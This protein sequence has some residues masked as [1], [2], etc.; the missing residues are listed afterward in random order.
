MKCYQIL[1]E[2]ARNGHQLT[3]SNYNIP[4]GLISKPKP[5]NLLIGVLT[6]IPELLRQTDEILEEHFG[7]IDLRSDILIFNFTDYYDEEMGKG[8]QRQFYSFEKLIMPDEI[9]TVKVQTNYLEECIATSKKY[10]PKRPANIDPGYMNESRLVLASTK[11]FS[12]RIYLRDGIYAEVTLNY[13]R[14]RYESFPWT[15]PDYKSADYQ[16]FFLL[17]RELYI[18]K[19]KAG[20]WKPSEK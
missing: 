9:A 6:N 4:V 18:K 17:A 5:V 2:L 7:P 10:P 1:D 16:N 12:H 14:G 13:R 15:F 8:I 3:L 20:K 19:L 11:D